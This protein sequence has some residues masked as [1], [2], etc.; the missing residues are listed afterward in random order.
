M[1][2]GVVRGETSSAFRFSE[3]VRYSTGGRGKARDEEADEAG[4]DI[5]EG[6]GIGLDGVFARADSNERNGIAGVA[7]SAHVLNI[8]VVAG[9]DNENAREGAEAD[10]RAEEGIERGEDSGGLRVGA[11]VAGEVGLEEF[12]EG[13][14][15]G[16]GDLNEMLGGE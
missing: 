1:L 12:K 16:A 7:A 2:I 15:V 6:G 9:E 14:V 5:G 13:E 3:R 8:A 4:S 10:E 11:G